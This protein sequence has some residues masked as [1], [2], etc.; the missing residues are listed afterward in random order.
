MRARAALMDG[1]PAGGAMLAVSAAE[2]DVRALLTD[3]VS[4]A[5]VNGPSSVVVAGTED[6][7]GSVARRVSEL[8][9]RHRRLSVSHAFHSPLMDP[10]LEEFAAALEGIEFR[11]PVIRLV[12]GDPTDPAYW[13]R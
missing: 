3:G 12:S 1:L 8:G 6:A 9:W 4:I 7:V 13:V 2:A 11:E 5:A 10:M